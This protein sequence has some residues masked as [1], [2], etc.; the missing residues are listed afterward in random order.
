MYVKRKPLNRM[1]KI[2]WFFHLALVAVIFLGCQDDEPVKKE[3]AK[4]GLV[5]FNVGSFTGAD[6]ASGRKADFLP[7]GMSL[8]VT[9]REFDG[10]TIYEFKKLTF[11]EIGGE[12]ISEGLALPP[13]HYQIM[14]FF[15]ANDTRVY[16]ACPKEDSELA[17]WVSDPLPIAFSVTADA[18]DFVSVDVIES[19]PFGPAPFG[20]SKFDINFLPVR[21]LTLA[22]L[23]DSASTTVMTA[24]H[25]TLTQ[26]RWPEADTVLINTHLPAKTNTVYFS[27]SQFGAYTLTV[28]VPG[29]VTYTR[30]INPAE[31]LFTQ[32]GR[33]LVINLQPALTFTSTSAGY[34]SFEME[35][36]PAIV[37]VDWGDGTAA[38][39]VICYTCE[40]THDYADL[41]THN[42]TITGRTE[43]ITGL[44][45]VSSA[46]NTSEISLLHVPYLRSFTMANTGS[47][48]YVDL[49]SNPNIEYINVGYSNVTAFS[50][51]EHAPISHISVANL[52]PYNFDAASLDE[53]IH[54][55]YASAVAAGRTGGFL[56]LGYFT[57]V[58]PISPEARQELEILR[59][60]YGWEIYGWQPYPEESKL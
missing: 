57:F 50:I 35:G 5:K 52:E 36:M 58:A 19:D 17:S 30:S 2:G 28:K 34:A 60:N 27:G 29:N 22:I 20:Y 48:T 26:H 39:E 15:L 12:F 25:I 45:F 10:P 42:I 11:L 37:S 6:A 49:R 16:Y 3:D 59:D 24:S 13:G 33:P 55:V 4:P 41:G 56:E 53:I 43:E 7:S 44:R 54:R 38:E 14:D 21:A 9:V 8:Y 32:E 1:K 40:L 47:P 23:K 46:A 51:P 18:V 31:L